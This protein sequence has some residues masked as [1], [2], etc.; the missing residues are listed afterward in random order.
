M[1]INCTPHD[2]NLYRYGKCYM[3]IIP[4]GDIARVEQK[5]IALGLI[6]EKLSDGSVYVVPIYKTVYGAVTGLPEQKEG[7]YYIVSTL[8]AQVC[9]QRADL[10]TPK[11]YVRD[12]NNRI[13][14]CL[15]L[16]LGGINLENTLS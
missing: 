16:G 6:E 3:T 10:L 4:S 11:Q 2:I 1:I 12:K 13:I 7:T 8:V 9:K 5:D 14:G 15:G